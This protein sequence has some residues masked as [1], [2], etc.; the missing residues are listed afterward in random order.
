MR[1]VYIIKNITNGYC[2]VGSSNN[3]ENRVG[4]HFELLRKKQHY[5]INLQ[6]A[7]NNKE[8][9]FI[10]GCVKEFD[11]F[12]TR[13]EIYDYEQ[14]VLDQ[15]HNRY[16]ILSNAKDHLLEDKLQRTIHRQLKINFDGF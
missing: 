3:I 5:N 8:S 7:F 12:A 11:V 15:V 10:Y 16:N 1:G 13:D 14:I 2:Y 4:D 6:R 9:Y